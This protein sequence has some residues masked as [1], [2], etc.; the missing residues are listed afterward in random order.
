MKMKIKFYFVLSLIL[1]QVFFLPPW[2]IGEG[3]ALLTLQPNSGFFL[4]GQNVF[5]SGSLSGENGPISGKDVGILVFNPVGGPLFADQVSTDSSGFFQTNFRL[6]DSAL[7]GSYTIQACANGASTSANFKVVTQLPPSP[8]QNLTALPGQNSVF[9][10]WSP[11]PS[12]AASFYLVYRKAPGELQFTRVATTSSLEYTDNFATACGQP[13]AYAVSAAD[14][15]GYEGDRSAEVTAIPYGH[16]ATFRFEGIATPQFSGIPFNIRIQAVDQ[17][18]GKVEDFTSRASL[19]PVP[20]LSG[21]ISPTLTEAF[22][23]GEWSGKVVLT[24]SGT[25]CIQASCSGIYGTSNEFSLQEPSPK[26][27]YLHSGW[28]LVS[29]PYQTSTYPTEVFSSLPQPWR[30]YWWDP[31]NSRYLS[32]DQP[33]IS[34]GRGFWVKSPVDILINFEGEELNSDSFT[35][36]LLPGWNMVGVPFP[37]SFSFEEIFLETGTATYDFSSAVSAGLI[38]NAAYFWDGSRYENAYKTGSGLE[39]FKGYWIKVYQ[40]CRLTFFKER[41]LGNTTDCQVLSSSYPLSL[42]LSFRNSLGFPISPPFHRGSTVMI[43]ATIQNNSSET[44][45][46]I[47]LFNTIDPSG[48]PFSFSTISAS[49]GPNQ[50]AIYSSSLSFPANAL[51]G[52]YQVRVFAWN[53]WPSKSWRALSS[54]GSVVCE[55]I[56]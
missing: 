19:S 13:Y 29:L 38:R 20:V 30:A 2:V 39:P 3:S 43:T 22:L 48:A 7:L 32:K 1:F 21:S 41:V 47:L 11:S 25:M 37:R 4:Q 45:P 36:D 49:L 10:S 42:S 31:S 33:F 5:L 17:W 16:L 46:F 54:P 44:V 55:L 14:A 53:S 52:N 15:T 23:E 9:L 8:P 18:G 27:L 56:P 34:P 51:T 12:P 28:N 6:P 40:P 26:S 24:G 35:F 50:S